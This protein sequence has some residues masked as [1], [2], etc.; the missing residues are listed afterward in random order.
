MC[1]ESIIIVTIKC[2]C[3]EWVPIE[4]LNLIIYSI[5]SI[6]YPSIKKFSNS[7]EKPMENTQMNHHRRRVFLYFYFVCLLCA[8]CGLHTR[9]NWVHYAVQVEN[10]IIYDVK[11]T[12][13]TLTTVENWNLTIKSAIKYCNYSTVYQ[14]AENYWFRFELEPG[15]AFGPPASNCMQKKW[16]KTQMYHQFEC[17]LWQMGVYFSI[18]AAYVLHIIVG[19]VLHSGWNGG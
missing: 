13:Y 18:E 4:R 12:R 17:I 6:F 14:C 8:Q 19:M 1:S 2:T 16:M 3:C 11:S 9:S 10:T 7:I 5:I 15:A